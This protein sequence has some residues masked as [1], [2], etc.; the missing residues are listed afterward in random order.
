M[1]FRNCF[2]MRAYPGAGK[3]FKA[4]ELAQEH[5]AVICSADDF[6]MKN[7][8]YE[9]DLK[10][11]SLAHKTCF[12]KFKKNVN[13]GKNVIIDNT[14]IKFE[15]IS[16]YIDYLVIHNK[17]SKILYKVD[18]IEVEYNNIDEAIKHRTNNPTGKDVPTSTIRKMY[19]GFK[20]IKAK[21][22]MYSKYTGKIE[23]IF[24]KENKIPSF[25][26][27][28]Y[29]NT[30]EQTVIC[31]LD[32]TISLFKLP[33][34]GSLRNPYDA[35]TANNDIMNVAV[36]KML[37]SLDFSGYQILF[38]SGR[39]EKFRDPTMEFLMRF[40]ETYNIEQPIILIMRE[41][42]DFRGD[43]IIKQEIY[44]N[45]IEP[46]YTVTAVFDDRRKVVRMWRELGLMVFDCN[47]LDED[48]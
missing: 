33:N 10:N 28:H 37:Q 14:N 17:I 20:K 32:G 34:G 27:G 13:E 36:A 11:A 46:K 6:H 7:G 9:F 29:D 39:E 8:R 44:A 16:K 22:L 19:D 30:K 4:N 35:S 42:G 48:F 40:K 26:E 12:E 18:I 45:Y 47:Y 24:P 25:F 38:V 31:D 21:S 5:D 43:E 2:I 23:F 3:S 1:E 15:D 41:L